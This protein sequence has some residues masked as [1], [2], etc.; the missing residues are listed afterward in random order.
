MNSLEYLPSPETNGARLHDRAYEV[1]APAPA[2]TPLQAPISSFDRACFT[3]LRFTE[4]LIGR[5]LGATAPVKRGLQSLYEANRA[6]IESAI[7]GQ[8]AGG[9]YEI[10]QCETIEPEEFRTKYLNAT[11]PLV[12]RGA[13]RNWRSASKWTPEF[14]GEKYGDDHIVL[15]DDHIAT[16]QSVGTRITLREIVDN[17]LS[18]NG[19]LAK[20]A[21]FV[22]ILAY[23]P[24]LLDDLDVPWLAERIDRRG[25]VK[26]WGER[27][28]GSSLRSHLFLG[29]KGAKTEVHCALTNNFFVNVYGRKQWYLISPS[30]DPM[31]Y[32]PVNWGPGLYGTELSPVAPDL[33]KFPL[34]RYVTGYKVVLEPSDVMFVPPFW[35][36]H[37]SNITH[38]ISIGIRWYSFANAM[39]SSSTQNLLALLATNPSLYAAARNSVEYWKH[40]EARKQG[41][42]GRR[43]FRRG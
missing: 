14:F 40:L 35:W 33:Q 21:R 36:H 38:C 42:I 7:Y 17:L 10:D 39:R 30:Y 2:G 25:Q 20:Y 23:H 27:K 26:L 34:Q 19:E 16:D 24:E 9:F 4:H 6:H 18:D 13:A 8:Q 11:R 3:A 28:R 22:P 5:K 32:S 1:M 15:T 12:I 43:I 29:R 37:V 41:G 31:M